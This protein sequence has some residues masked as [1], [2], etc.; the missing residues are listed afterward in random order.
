[1]PNSARFTSFAG[2]LIVVS[3]GVSVCFARRRATSKISWESIERPEGLTRDKTSGHGPRRFAHADQNL[4]VLP[5]MPRFGRRCH[6]PRIGRRYRPGRCPRADP[7][8]PPPVTGG[9]G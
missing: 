2:T 7:A 6:V 4:F 1:M 3:A 8:R 5:R 9:G